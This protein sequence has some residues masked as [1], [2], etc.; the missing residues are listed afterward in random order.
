MRSE[1]SQQLT[2]AAGPWAIADTDPRAARDVAASTPAWYVAAMGD[3]YSRS[4]SNNGYAH[5][6]A[7]VRAANPRPR[8]Q[9]GVVPVDAERILHEFAAY[10]TSNQVRDRLECWD[11]AADIVVVGCPPGIPW[12]MIESTLRAAAPGRG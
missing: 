6:V 9:G 1:R 10:G 3:V 2:I 8:M 11:G 4:L 12:P 5:E 7:A